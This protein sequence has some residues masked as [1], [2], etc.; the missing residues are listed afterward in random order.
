MLP[1]YGAHVSRTCQARH[2]SDNAAAIFFLILL[3]SEGQKGEAW[4]P[5]DKAMLL[6]ISRSTDMAVTVRRVFETANKN[7]LG[8]GT[9]SFWRV[10]FLTSLQ[11]EGIIGG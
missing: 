8:K 5:A 1:H 4:G 6:W 2:H 7:R 10:V 11:I 9:S 3:L